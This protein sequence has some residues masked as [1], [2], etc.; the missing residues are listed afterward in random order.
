LRHASYA[1]VNPAASMNACGHPGALDW[2]TIQNTNACEMWRPRVSEVTD[3]AESTT[4]HSILKKIEGL[5]QEEQHLY[6]KGELA[7]H[8]Q[9][10]LE[11]IRIELDQCW[12]LLRQRE[13]RREFGQDPDEAKVRPPSVVERYKQ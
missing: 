9:V 7:N 6:G 1:N 13:A 11:A 3:M 4:D 2:L 8:D 10:R 5:V 12:D